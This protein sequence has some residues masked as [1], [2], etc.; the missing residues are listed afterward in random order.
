MGRPLNK[1][2]FGN[3]NIGTTTTTDN[4]IGGEGVASVTIGGT[5]NAYVAVPTVTFADPTLPGG[6]TAT[7]SA[8]MGVVGVTLVAAGT[9]YAVNDVITLAAGAGAGT[10]ATLT[11]TAITGG[12][13]TGPIDT[14]SIT[15]AGNYT[16]ITD[17]TAVGVT[18][19][20][21]DDATFDLTFKVN[22]ITV[23]EKGSG[24]V[25]A[26][27]ITMTGNAT[28]TA[29]LTTDSGSAG[30]STNQENA[31]VCTAFIPAANGGTQ[32]STGDIVKQTNDRRYKVKTSEGTG[33]CQLVTDG[34]ANAAGEISI[35]ATDSE[36][37][38]Y[39]VAKLTSRK[40]V[41]VPAA[42][43]GQAGTQFA[44]GTSAKW[45]FGAAVLNTTV[46]IENA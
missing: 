39:L 18:G 7:G 23:T 41:L 16:T 22:S 43:G 31:I 21:N 15:T 14:V 30:S 46:T 12:G 6:V 38:N 37:K 28:K 32:A 44:S 5:N 19:P 25:S 1:K 17:V 3:R 11:V 33:I 8:V 26:P 34:V 4:G 24:Y 27:A 13:A 36:G 20:G 9:G 35:K 42:L 2:Y 45:T 10:A 40:V 29:V